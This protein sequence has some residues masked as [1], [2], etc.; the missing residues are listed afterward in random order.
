MYT[1]TMIPMKDILS[2]SVVKRATTGTIIT[3]AWLQ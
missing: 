1:E 3:L 2:S